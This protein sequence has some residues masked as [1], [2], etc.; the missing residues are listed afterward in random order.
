MRNQ[1]LCECRTRGF[2]GASGKE[3]ETIKR[4]NNRNKDIGMRIFFLAAFFVCTSAK[5][6]A[7]DASDPGWPYYGHDAGGTRYSPLTQINRDNVS[8]LQ[9]A[10]TFHVEDIS[11]GSD[12]RK[13]TGLETTPI[14]VDDTLYLTSGY[15]RVFA[16][17]PETG[18]KKWVYD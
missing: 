13:R 10:W 18:K 7:Q 12:G 5:I 9:V 16:I 2:A 6:S 17:D 8:K 4:M 3:C 15:N 1:Q 11:D 14:L